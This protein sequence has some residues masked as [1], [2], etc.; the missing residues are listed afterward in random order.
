MLLVATLEIL[1]F[2]ELSEYSNL[3]KLELPDSIKILQLGKNPKL[4]NIKNIPKSLE[5]IKYN[6]LNEKITKLIE[7]TGWIGKIEYWN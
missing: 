3:D 2:D 1:K 4:H 5:Y 7:E 6:K